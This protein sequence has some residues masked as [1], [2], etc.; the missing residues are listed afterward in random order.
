VLEGVPE[1]EAYKIA[2]GNA[3]RML[4]LDPEPLVTEPAKG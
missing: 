4:D 1:D 2:R 3:I